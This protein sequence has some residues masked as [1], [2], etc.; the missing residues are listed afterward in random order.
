MFT[1]AGSTRF[2]IAAKELDEGMTSGTVSG[3]AV[4]PANPRVFIAETRPD[5]TDP[6]RIP[7][8][9]VSATDNDARIL[10]RRAQLNSSCPFGRGARRFLFSTSLDA[11][12][13]KCVVRAVL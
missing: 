2:T 6:I 13:A 9:S 10:R 12:N 3:V 1:T 4:V 11:A 8:A 7:T 5:M